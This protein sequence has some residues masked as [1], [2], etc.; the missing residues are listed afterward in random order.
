MKKIFFI[1]QSLL[2]LVT[3]VNAQD[4]VYPARPET[5]DYLIENATIHVGNGKVINNGSIIISKGKIAAVLEGNADVAKAN[6]IVIDAKGKQVYPGLILP[7][8]D[9]G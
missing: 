8:T 3:V 9:L 1:I 6:M 4:D 5:Q 2:L 7:E